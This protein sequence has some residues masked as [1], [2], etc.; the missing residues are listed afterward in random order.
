[1]FKLI[2]WDFINFIK[3]YSWIYICLAA[4]FVLT[5]LLS[6]KMGFLSIFIDGICLIYSLLFFMWTI[7]IPFKLIV[8]WLNKA[9]VLLEL[10][11]P[12]Q[13]WQI[14]LSKFVVPLTVNF[15]G[16]LLS[17]LLW[18]LIGHFGVSNAVLFNGITS[19]LQYFVGMAILI[20]AYLFSYVL[21][22]NF[23]FIPK[24]IN[25]IAAGI[26]MVLLCICLFSAACMFFSGTG[27]WNITLNIYD[28]GNVFFTIDSG[29]SML[30]IILETVC[31]LA[32]VLAGFLGSCK[33]IDHHQLN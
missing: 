4:A 14:L 27:L 10:S 16:I 32:I 15:S 31:V 12:V 9:S 6:N 29:K 11:L 24:K 28:G 26:I 1:M 8:S 22:K 33:L 17:S 30:A 13:L 7:I 21:V 18:K 2:K 19:L 20:E 5:G 25:T 3:K 23:R